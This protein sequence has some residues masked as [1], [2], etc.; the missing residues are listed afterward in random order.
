MFA[1][2]S[3]YLGLRMLMH[4]IPMPVRHRVNAEVSTKNQC[5][6]EVHKEYITLIPEQPVSSGSSKLLELEHDTLE[7]VC[8]SMTCTRILQRAH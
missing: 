7:G 1:W 4:P 6:E 2:A 8:K 5:V 3:M